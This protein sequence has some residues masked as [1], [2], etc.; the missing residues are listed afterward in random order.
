MRVEI[1]DLLRNMLVNIAK[2][3]F[4][5]DISAAAAEQPN[6]QIIEIFKSEIPDFSKYKLAKAY[7]RWTRGHTSN[8]LSIAERV[9]WTTLIEKINASF[10]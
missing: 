2:T 3:E 5:W 1:E 6:R 7:V 10:D 8:D 9:Q 4:R